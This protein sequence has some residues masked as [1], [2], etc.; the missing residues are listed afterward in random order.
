MNQYVTLSIQNTDVHHLGVQVDSAVIFVAFVV[1]FHVAFSCFKLM[2]GDFILKRSFDGA[3][4]KVIISIKALLLAAIR[5]SR[6]NNYAALHC[7]PKV[8]R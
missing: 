2:F 1:E 4:E 6:D 8:R 5:R 7:R 3:R